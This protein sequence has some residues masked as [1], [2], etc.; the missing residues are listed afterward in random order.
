[1]NIA[2]PKFGSGVSLHRV[3]AIARLA[4]L[5]LARWR[6]R[7]AV[8]A[9]SSG[10]GSVAAMLARALRE[11]IPRVGLFTS[12][13]LM[14]MNERFAV[15]GEDASDEALAAAFARIEDAAQA[16]ERSRPDDRLGGFEMLYLAACALFEDADFAV[17]ECGIGGRYDCTRLNRARRGALVSLSLEHT[18][19]LGPTLELIAYDKLDAVAPDGVV[20]LGES[21]LPLRSR[22]ETY[23][24]LTGVSPI[25]LSPDRDWRVIDETLEVA[26]PDGRSIVATPALAGPHQRNNAA[27][28]ARLAE[29]ILAE[30]DI[31]LARRDRAIKAGIEDV[32]WPGR[33]ERISADPEIIID[34]GHTPD[35]VRAAKT[36]YL[37]MRQRPRSILV[38]GASNDKD[39][40]GMIEALAPG[41]D[42]AI[43]TAARHKGR[44]AGE[45]AAALRACRPDLP[46]IEVDDISQAPA[47][48]RANARERDASI[49]V[50]GGLFLA[51]EFKAAYFNL[52]STK[53]F[54]F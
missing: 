49:Y 33:L 24:G 53:L 22:I 41:F 32:R 15:N 54:F 2:R 18:A 35:A 39:A 47:I 26:M 20:Y 50:A 13:H 42:L 34:V 48:A 43:A 6:E 9:G 23:T 8:I 3:A 40:R 14:R 21:C 36:G 1:M 37:A 19:I 11:D 7:S 29:A 12:P 25:F 38:C 17:F 44:A 52:D 16:Y 4:G 31:A 46:V 30:R 27:I 10:K 28:A 45:I 5:D 51:A